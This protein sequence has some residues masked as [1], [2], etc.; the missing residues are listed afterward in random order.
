VQTLNHVL[1]PGHTLIDVLTSAGVPTREALVATLELESE[2]DPR[3]LQA[4]ETIAL[5]LGNRGDSDPA[6][7]LESLRLI[8]ETDRVVV[9]RHQQDEVF[10]TEVD[11]IEHT[12][13]FV[14]AAG[15]IDNSLYESARAQDVPMSILLQTYATLG[16]AVDFQRDIHVGDTFMLG[17]EIFDDG[18][19]GGP[20]AGGL[21]YASLSLEN[22]EFTFYRYTTGDGYTGFFDANG[23]SVETSLMRTPV[24]GGDISSLFGKRKHPVLG[25]TRMHKGLDFAANRGAPVLAA[26]DGVVVERKRNGGFGRYVRLRHDGVYS[27]VYAHLSRY[28]QGLEPGD[29]V[30]QGDVIGY[31]GS[32][33][34]ATGPNLH[35]EVLSGEEQVNPLALDLPPRRVLQGEEFVWFKR[36]ANRVSKTIQANSADSE[37]AESEVAVRPETERLV[38]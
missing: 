37:P 32:S 17:F 35:Y 27:T 16:H 19:L 22:R 12:A 36:S 38:L 24:D 20:H 11:S 23:R 18:D 28:A 2:V 30:L 31:V 33:G 5:E 8:P 7:H 3:S 29:R 26:G 10:A 6:L 25:Y 21:V 1:E 4:G 9:V 34:L 13:R 15:E 14:S